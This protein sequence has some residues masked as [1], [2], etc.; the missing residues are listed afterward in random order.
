MDRSRL[1]KMLCCRGKSMSPPP[2][3]MKES[4]P[5]MPLCGCLACVRIAEMRWRMYRKR[6]ECYSIRQT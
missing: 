4:V 3:P 2:S 5:G 1:T 6:M